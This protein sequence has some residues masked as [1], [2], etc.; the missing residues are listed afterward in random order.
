MTA[1]LGYFIASNKTFSIENTICIQ[2]LN[3]VKIYVG[4]NFRNK[5]DAQIAKKQA[6]QA[7]AE[8]W[9]EEKRCATTLK[10]KAKRCKGYDF[11]KRIGIEMLYLSTDST[12]LGL[13][14]HF[15]FIT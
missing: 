2:N 9:L 10:E 3:K 6:M 5:F 7:I 13:F 8:E 14:V 1:D 4:E 11:A 15:L 12:F